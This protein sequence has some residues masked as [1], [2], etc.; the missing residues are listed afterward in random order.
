VKSCKVFR[1]IYKAST[2]VYKVFFP[3]QIREIGLQ[4]NAEKTKKR[5]LMEQSGVTLQFLNSRKYFV[6]KKKKNDNNNK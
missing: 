5:F 3:S 4:L 2:N 6:K 1:E